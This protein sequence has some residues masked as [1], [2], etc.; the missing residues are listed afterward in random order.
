M[1]KNLDLWKFGAI[2]MGL[3]RAELYLP[4]HVHN[5]RDIIGEGHDDIVFYIKDNVIIGYFSK[6]STRKTGKRG[7]EKLKN[8]NFIK[9]NKKE[10]HKLGDEIYSISDYIQSLPLKHIDIKELFKHYETL[11]KI[12]QKMFGYFNLSQPAI[13]M[14]LEDQIEKLMGTNFN[15]DQQ[16][17]IMEIMLKQEDNTL[18]E[19]EEKD[20][21]KI[22]LKIKK[23]YALVK[24][25]NKDFKS[26]FNELNFFKDSIIYK[27]LIYH[28]TKYECLAS[29]ENFDEF[30]L[31]YFLK[32]LRDFVNKSNEELK[33]ELLIKSP[34]K[35]KLSKERKNIIKKYNLSSDLVH[36]IDTVRYYSHQRMLIRIYW[37]KALYVW[38]KILREF[39]RRMNL[40]ENQIQYV[41]RSEIKDFVNK[42]INPFIEEIELRRK[43]CVYAIFDLNEPV[44]LTG[45]DA[46]NFYKKY[47]KPLEPNTDTVKGMPASK[48][49]KKGKVKVLS[50]GKN[51]VNQIEEMQQGDI[52]VTGN[53]RPDMILALKKASAVVTNEGGI[54]SHAA[55]VSREFGIPCIVGTKHATA[56]FKDG[57]IIEVDANKGIA[58]K[59]NE[60]YKIF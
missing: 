5:I 40:S 17:E 52:L 1:N 2:S 28:K 7:L 19:E 9:K 58:K 50:Y 56:V 4:T 33:E 41:L 32:R 27:D 16:Y 53:T 38:G 55:L 49:Y 29:S 24:L 22:A 59:L 60:T 45:V 54:M 44:L 57:D 21:I 47:L 18:I 23:N 35:N 51:M 31:D 42:K 13:S 43:P 34:N 3:C 10:V 12:I 26:F 36:I 39:A 14:A 30:S 15:A 6:K 46:E 8:I 11:F 25:L 20:L 48:G 37:T